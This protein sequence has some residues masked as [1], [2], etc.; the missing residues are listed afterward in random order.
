LIAIQV[1]IAQYV[2]AYWLRIFL[3]NGEEFAEDAN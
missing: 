1:S 3:H 2:F